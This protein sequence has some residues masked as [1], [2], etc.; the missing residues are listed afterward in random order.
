MDFNYY[1]IQLANRRNLEN[2]IMNMLCQNPETLLK[3]AC[4]SGSQRASGKLYRDNLWLN[5]L[6]TSKSEVS[7]LQ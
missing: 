3:N 6:Y 1:S 5:G 4:T 2:N 7:L